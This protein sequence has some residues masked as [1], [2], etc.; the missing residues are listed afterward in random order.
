MI[1]MHL[2]DLPMHH[3]ALQQQS[4]LYAEVGVML[5]LRQNAPDPQHC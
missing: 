3:N 5:N 2:P 4:V 1:D